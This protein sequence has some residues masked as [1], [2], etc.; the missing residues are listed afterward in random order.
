MKTE[1]IK[2]YTS[3]VLVFSTYNVFVIYMYVIYRKDIGPEVVMWFLK[4]SLIF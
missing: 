3:H 4:S 2:R 1:R